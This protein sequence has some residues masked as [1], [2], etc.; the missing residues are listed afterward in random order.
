MVTKNRLA[1]EAEDA[2]GTVVEGYC[3]AC[4]VR[5][6]RPDCTCCPCCGGDFEAGPNR[7]RMGSC[8]QHRTDCVH[9]T[10]VWRAS[11]AWY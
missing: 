2:I 5:L 7:L 1:S 6:G 4:R 11:R 8:D 3:P 10:E 9:W